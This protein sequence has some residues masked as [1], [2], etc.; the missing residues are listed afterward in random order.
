MLWRT[1]IKLYLPGPKLDL[2]CQENKDGLRRLGF[3]YRRPDYAFHRPP[4]RYP[5]YKADPLRDTATFFLRHH[6]VAR[7]MAKG[8]LKAP[9]PPALMRTFPVGSSPNCITFKND[10]WYIGGKRFKSAKE[11]RE[12]FNFLHTAADYIDRVGK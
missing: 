6:Y 1:D 9:V 8:T 4:C 7:N 11:M 12:F 10:W 2:R 3:F 5:E